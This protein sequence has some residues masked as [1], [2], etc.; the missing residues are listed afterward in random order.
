MVKTLINAYPDFRKDYPDSD[1]YLE[2]AEFFFDTIQG[3]GINIGHPAAFLRLQNCTM[4]CRWCDTREVWRMGNPYTFDELFELI[5]TPLVGVSLLQRL[6]NGQHLVLTGGSPLMQQE[7]LI[8]FLHEFADK[9]GFIPYI[10]VENECVVMP[11]IEMLKI[12]NCW[13]NSPKLSNSGNATALRYQP[14]VIRT[15]A[16]TS[17]S[18]FKFVISRKEDW[19]EIQRDFLD[20]DL[21]YIGH[22]ILMPQG[23]TREELSKNREMV[24]ELAIEKGVRYCTREHVVIWDKKT[25]V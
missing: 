2:V 22:I 16:N 14:D 10:E 21:I 25:G 23:A 1:D 19:D 17:D 11:D 9:Y 3:E 12:V 15:V 6:E 13:N 5:E 7:R 4:N 18:W 8:K 24:I 20:T